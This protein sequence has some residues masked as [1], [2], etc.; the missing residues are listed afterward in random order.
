MSR[1]IIDRA[2]FLITYG[3]ISKIKVNEQ[4][5]LC[6]DYILPHLL[7]IRILINW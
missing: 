2:Y 4:A 6:Q 3:L 5:A 1:F 7:M